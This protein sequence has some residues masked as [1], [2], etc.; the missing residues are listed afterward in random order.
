MLYCKQ[1]IK[2]NSLI[3]NLPHQYSFNLAL[4][5]FLP[6]YQLSLAVTFTITG[7]LDGR[8]NN[9]KQLSFGQIYYHL[10]ETL[11]AE[12]LKKTI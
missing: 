8:P 7:K 3:R 9:L 6:F 1:A 12:I 5:G 11:N 2:K 4:F 10:D